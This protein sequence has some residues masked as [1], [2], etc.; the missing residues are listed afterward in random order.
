VG[1]PAFV[2]VR[3]SARVAPQVLLWNLRHLSRS[4]APCDPW[5]LRP[6]C[7]VQPTVGRA[8]LGSLMPRWPP[9]QEHLQLLLPALVRL[10][11]PVVAA[12]PVEVRRAG[13]ASMRRLLP[14]MQ[15]AG[16]A[17]GVLQ[18]LIRIID[19]PVEE[20]RRD[21][22]DTV[23]SLALALGP[24]FSIFIGSIRKAR[25]GAPGQGLGLRVWGLG[26]WISGL[27]FQVQGEGF[28]DACARAC[29]KRVQCS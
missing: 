20:L 19:G 16:H 28:V 9:T 26:F 4:V 2:S 6:L 3:C 8:V 13:M 7:S 10:I 23:C 21:A 25:A 24:D 12:V 15:L 1:A 5:R 22:L 14:R 11:C 18:P 17:S 29:S 27:G